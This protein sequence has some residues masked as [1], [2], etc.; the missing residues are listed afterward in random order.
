MICREEGVLSCPANPLNAANGFAAREA[1]SSEKVAVEKKISLFAF[2]LICHF[3]FPP[4]PVDFVDC[5]ANKQGDAPEGGK[6]E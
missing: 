2:V 1:L 3:V 6:D 4:I 5:G